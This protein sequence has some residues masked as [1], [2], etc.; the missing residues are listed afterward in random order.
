MNL[1]DY[2]KWRAAEYRMAHDPTP[3]TLPWWVTPA[4]FV[5]YVTLRIVAALW[6]ACSWLRKSDPIELMV[7]LWA[8]VCIGLFLAGMIVA[9]F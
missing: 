3:D 6:D 7:A 9:L 5:G 4:A 1:Q 2:N 8:T